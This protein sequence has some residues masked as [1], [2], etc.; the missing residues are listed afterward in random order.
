[1]DYQ[2]I[3]VS[4]TILIF[5]IIVFILIVDKIKQNRL[6]IRIT[7]IKR[8]CRICFVIQI[9]VKENRIAYWKKIK[10]SKCECSRHGFYS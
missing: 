8:I 4:P 6:F 9:L 5:L 10:I 7:P 2:L 1:M 3:L